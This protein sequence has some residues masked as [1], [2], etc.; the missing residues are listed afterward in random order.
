MCLRACLNN[1]CTRQKKTIRLFFRRLLSRK[2]VVW[3]SPLILI[4]LYDYM[5]SNNEIRPVT[6]ARG[7][8]E[9]KLKRIVRI[10]VRKQLFFSPY[11]LGLKSRRWG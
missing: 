3:P 4:V 5:D 1:G 9:R 7:K 8:T 6:K 10:K 2:Q 11:F